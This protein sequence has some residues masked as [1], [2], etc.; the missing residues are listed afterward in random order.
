MGRFLYLLNT[1]GTPK[2]IADPPRG[3]TITVV[4]QYEFERSDLDGVDGLLLS[5]HLDETHLGELR[6]TLAAFLDDGGTVS[7]NGPISKP[8]LD[9]P[10]AYHGLPTQ[11]A[12]DWLIEMDTLHPITRGVRAEDLSMRMGV[13]GFWARGYFEAPSNAVVLTRFAVSG[14]PADWVWRSPGGGAL[15]VHPGND[16]WGYAGDD[17][18]ARPF[19]AQFLDWAGAR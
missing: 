16:I 3:H 14:K 9:P 8:F 18:T 5:Q 2:F 19:F 6:V 12:R 15:L 10:G 17:T 7:L 11:A 1:V 4:D 13:I